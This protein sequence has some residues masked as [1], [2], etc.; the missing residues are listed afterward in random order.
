MGIALLFIEIFPRLCYWLTVWIRII[1]DFFTVKI[2]DLFFGDDGF[3]NYY[4]DTPGYSSAIR[5]IRSNWSPRKV[6]Y[7]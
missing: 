1:H 5:I 2:F 4:Q 6:F 3:R 7:Y